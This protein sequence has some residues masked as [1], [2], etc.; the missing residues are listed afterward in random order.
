MPSDAATAS[1]G[2]PWWPWR[3]ELYIKT[4]EAALLA[5]MSTNQ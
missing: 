2:D 4:L 3:V 1:A 5:G